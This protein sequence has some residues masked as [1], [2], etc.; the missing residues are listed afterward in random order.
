[1]SLQHTDET[2][3]LAIAYLR[4]CAK[5]S[6]EPTRQAIA[7]EV[8][9]AIHPEAQSILTLLEQVKVTLP[10]A[11]L[12]ATTQ[13]QGGKKMKEHVWRR[14]IKKLVQGI[15]S[16]QTLAWMDDDF[17]PNEI[18]FIRRVLNDISDRFSR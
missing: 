15:I 10:S 4:S 7:N 2:Q 11:M 9:Q 6:D 12:P 5:S 16:P 18:H 8:N 13:T 1:M 14:E 17:R 3:A